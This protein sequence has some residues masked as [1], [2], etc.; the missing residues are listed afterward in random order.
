MAAPHLETGVSG[1]I[2]SFP[3]MAVILAVFAHAMAGFEAAKRVLRGLVGGLYSFAI[4]FWV[5]SQLR[6]SFNLAATYATAFLAALVSAHK[7]IIL[8]QRMA[9]ANWVSPGLV[10]ACL[11]LTLNTLTLSL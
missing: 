6:V 3:F 8:R 5:L 4:F 11:L 2:A 9:R 1:V 7:G 10:V